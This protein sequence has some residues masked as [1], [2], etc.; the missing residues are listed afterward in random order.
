MNDLD[1]DDAL[2]AHAKQIEKSATGALK[3]DG[4]SNK[5]SLNGVSER[6]KI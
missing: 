6:E 5:A 3:M 2:Q 4:W 1:H